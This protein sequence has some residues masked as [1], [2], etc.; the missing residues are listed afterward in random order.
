MPLN[1]AIRRTVAWLNDKGFYTCDSGDGNTHDFECD[2][3]YAY[4][5]VEVMD[6]ARLV[7]EARRLRNVLNSHGVVTSPINPV[8]D[9]FVQGDVAK[10]CIQA[11]YD[12]ENDAAFIELM[13]VDDALM[14]GA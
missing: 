11:S 14:F 2:R 10:P 6:P 7:G 5:V 3:D 4:V 1:K 12:P 9:E 13:F 8:D